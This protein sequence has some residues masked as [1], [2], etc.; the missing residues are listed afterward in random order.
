MH[1]L[2]RLFHNER[3][4]LLCR[5]NVRSVLKMINWH[6]RWRSRVSVYFFALI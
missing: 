5:N 6:K 3:D 1:D 4:S 2:V